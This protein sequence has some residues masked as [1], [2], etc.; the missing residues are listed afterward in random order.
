MTGCGGEYRDSVGEG[1]SVKASPV[2][3]EAT[4]R[5]QNILS[6][7]TNLRHLMEVTWK[8][9]RHFEE[10]PDTRA[11]TGSPSVLNK[12]RIPGELTLQLEAE[13]GK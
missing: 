2:L 5:S 13:P 3:R 8:S 12:V 6:L 9:L 10:L 1:V 7:V 4:L 11:A